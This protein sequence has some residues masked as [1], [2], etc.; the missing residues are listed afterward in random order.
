MSKSI[1]CLFGLH[2]YRKVSNKNRRGTIAEET[3]KEITEFK[4]PYIRAYIARSKWYNREVF[5]ER[6][7]YKTIHDQICIK[8]GKVKTN[9]A[10]YKNYCR[11]EVRHLIYK[12][13]VDHREKRLAEKMYKEKTK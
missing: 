1:R 9:V 4:A 5:N 10:D 11:R 3:V 2:K 13:T 8:C 7:N 6:Y 12:A